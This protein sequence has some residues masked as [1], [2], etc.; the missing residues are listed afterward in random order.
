LPKLLTWA[1]SVVG[2]SF[3]SS[4]TLIASRRL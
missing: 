2:D 1:A 3:V 4:P